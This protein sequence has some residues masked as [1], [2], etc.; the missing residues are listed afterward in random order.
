MKAE[1]CS[2]SN[3]KTACLNDTGFTLCQKHQDL[4]DVPMILEKRSRET[5][6]RILLRQKT[7]AADWTLIERI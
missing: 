3:G 6:E 4:K 2:S 5:R 1:D 7:V